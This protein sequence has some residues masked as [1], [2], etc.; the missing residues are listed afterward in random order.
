FTNI[1]SL[2]G[3]GKQHDNTMFLNVDEGRNE[4]TFPI[5]DLNNTNFGNNQYNIS[6]L[7]ADNS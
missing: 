7:S 6:Y 1:R 3:Q 4:F 2:F 5:S